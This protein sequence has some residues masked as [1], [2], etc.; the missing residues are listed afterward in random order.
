MSFKKFYLHKLKLNIL[1]E[2]YQELKNT[3]IKESK[4]N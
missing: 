2:I 1:Y 4:I 3:I